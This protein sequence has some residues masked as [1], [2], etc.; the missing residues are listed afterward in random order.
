MPMAIKLDFN[1]ATVD[2]FGRLAEKFDAH[3]AGGAL[4]ALL[5]IGA[6]L[7]IGISAAIVAIARRGT[8]RQRRANH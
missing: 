2:A 7:A 6:I 1:P 3:L 5:V 4:V 8:R